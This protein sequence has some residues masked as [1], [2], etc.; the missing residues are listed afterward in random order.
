[1]CLAWILHV[2]HRPYPAILCGAGT[3]V[4]IGKRPTIASVFSYWIVLRSY[5]IVLATLVRPTCNTQD[6]AFVSESLEL[7][8]QLNASN[9]AHLLPASLPKPR[10]HCQCKQSDPNRDHPP[11]PVQ[12]VGG[13]FES[14]SDGQ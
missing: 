11:P 7:D 6:S 14:D 2:K 5:G 9:H 13:R 3:S 1:M 10:D 8:I 12:C 4:A